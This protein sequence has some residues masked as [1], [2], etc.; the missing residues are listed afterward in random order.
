MHFVTVMQDI[1]ELI[2]ERE[3]PGS[4]DIQ[5][6]KRTYPGPCGCSASCNTS[7]H[8]GFMIRALLKKKLELH[9][10]GIF[11]L[12]T[13]LLSGDREGSFER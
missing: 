11:V 12:H 9:L 2:S 8:I 13:G 4:E 6:F 10:I 1:L 7:S 3:F 5:I